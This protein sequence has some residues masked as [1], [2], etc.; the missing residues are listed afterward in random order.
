MVTKEDRLCLIDFDVPQHRLASWVRAFKPILNKDMYT[1]LGLPTQVQLYSSKLDAL[2]PAPPTFFSLSRIESPS[3]CHVSFSLSQLL[4]VFTRTILS[5]IH[6]VSNP[7][8]LPLDSW[9]GEIIQGCANARTYYIQTS[10]ILAINCN[11]VEIAAGKF[12]T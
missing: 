7:F 5:A 9:E 8:A 4:Q 12:K 10:E 2:S 6:S 1:L 3:R 11:I